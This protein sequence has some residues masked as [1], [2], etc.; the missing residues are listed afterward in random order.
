MDPIIAGIVGIIAFFI[1]LIFRMPVSYAMVIVGFA[2]FAHLTS[3]LKAFNVVARDFYSIFSSYSLTVAP[4]F[5][6]M[7]F[8]AY[9]SGIGMGLF[10]LV[11]KFVGHLRGGLALSVQAACALF[12]AVCGS[13]PATVATMG[14]I[15]LP[16]MKKYKYADSLSTASVAAGASLG[17][18]IPPSV[19]FIIYGI[20]TEQSIGRLFIAGIIPGLLH[21]SIYM[22]TI[23]LLTTY[24]PSLAPITPKASWKERSGAIHDGGLI[25]V[26]MVFL[27]SL[28][29]LFMGW[30]TP[31]EAG[32]VGAFSIFVITF[33][34]KKMDWPKLKLALADTTKLTAMIFLLV[35]G[36]TVFGRFF[37]ITRIPFELSSWVAGLN[38]PPFL[39]MGVVI[40]IYFILGTVI[41]ALALILLTIPIFY[42]LVVTTLGYDPIWFGVIIL[43][44]TSMGVMT[45][46]V[47]LNVYIVKSVSKD[48]PL[49]T[50]F[51]G[52][53][54]F[55]LADVVTITIL[56]AFPVIATILPDLL[57]N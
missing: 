54:P 31:T 23:L 53:W 48:V 4:M 46:P 17:S 8:I 37:A 19:L 7:G 38:M 57:F 39:V 15:A 18:L 27:L 14:S 34:E 21:M 10:N 22:I 33:V 55:V 51:K 49:E 3:P 29:G 44:I 40:L 16:E 2:G 24:K 25:E 5:I 9:Y 43:L 47:G 1:L 12:G 36:A 6:L 26:A 45:P 13:L 42:P 28:G 11:N 32:A 50:I 35:A 52:I 30:F 56:I 41:D 20:A